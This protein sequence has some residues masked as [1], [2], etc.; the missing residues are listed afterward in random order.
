M[1]NRGFA[2]YGDRLFMVT[3]DAHFVALEMKT[4]KVIYDIE[5]A[6]G[7]DGF[8]GTGA[9]LVV[10]DK[11]IVGVAGGEFANRGFI[12]AYDP[13]TGER[14]WR[15][16][17][18][19]APGEHGSDSWTRRDL[20]ARRRS[21]LADRAPTIPRSI[22]CIGARAIRTPTGTARAAPATT[23]TPIRWSR[24]IRTPAN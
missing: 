14:L 11:V 21:D 16:Y 15:F 23:S 9:P 7:E 13:M 1:V 2:V 20:A 19:P 18:I 5:M 22:C 10:N 3:L 12:D 8:A 6:D 24:S 4:G 17:T